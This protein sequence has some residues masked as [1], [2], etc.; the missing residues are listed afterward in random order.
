MKIRL[1]INLAKLMG[2]KICLFRNANT[3]RLILGPHD[4][5][6]HLQTLLGLTGPA[7]IVIMAY[8]ADD[9]ETSVEI[10]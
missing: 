3:P 9:R 6:A 2:L 8:P 7:N 1:L 5:E 4:T 10:F